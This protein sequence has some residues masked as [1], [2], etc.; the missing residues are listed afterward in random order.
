MSQ[1]CHRTGVY[2]KSGIQSG[3]RSGLDISH[4]RDFLALLDKMWVFLY[5]YLVLTTRRK[6]EEKYDC[7]YPSVNAKVW[8]F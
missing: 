6:K 1:N 3:G 2:P 8:G 4:K 5:T 7:R